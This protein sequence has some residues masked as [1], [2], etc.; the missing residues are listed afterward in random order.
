MLEHALAELFEDQ[1]AENPP[2]THTSIPAA[3]RRGRAGVR[4][5]RV[6][7]IGAPILAAAAVLAIALTTL[8]VTGTRARPG[9]RPAAPAHAALAHFSLTRPYGWIRGL[10]SGSA[11]PAVG[12]TR[13]E[14][15]VT[16]VLSAK[17]LSFL[18]LNVF[19]PGLCHVQA[20][21]L[22]CAAV[23]PAPA[24][25]YP[26]GRRVATIDGY[27]AFWD[28]GE[29]GL[30][31]QYADRGWAS[32]NVGGQRRGAL[33]EIIQLARSASFGS[34]AAPPFVY[35]IALRSVPADWQVSAVGGTVWRGRVLP[36]AYYNVTAGPVDVPNG[37]VPIPAG[38]PQISVLKGDGCP[39]S[40]GQGRSTTRVINGV[41]VTVA[42]YS[43][44][45]PHLLCARHVDGLA[46]YFQVGGR[47][48]IG[49]IDLFAHH[50]HLLGPDPAHWTAQ[51]VSR[52]N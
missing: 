4:R 7:A 14:E 5:R 48:A 27:G 1:A 25:A 19:A 29:A 47:P 52:D 16:D 21:T 34:R 43:A 8:A 31:W 26:I 46:F 9:A 36:A 24:S 38:T 37:N 33:A 15:N 13:V 50:M 10:P 20:Q 17:P 30:T 35:P 28:P 11:A 18:D 12:M 40:P 22:R 51:L 39:S 45:V 6:A 41:R 49:V 42:D 2:P 32:L 44:G 3:L 23:A